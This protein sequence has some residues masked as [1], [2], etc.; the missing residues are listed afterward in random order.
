MPMADCAERISRAGFARASCHERSTTVSTNYCLRRSDFI[1]KSL[2]FLFVRHRTTAY[3][4]V[5]LRRV[6]EPL[7]TTGARLRGATSVIKYALAHHNARSGP[8]ATRPLRKIRVRATSAL[9]MARLAAWPRG[10]GT[11]G[12]DPSAARSRRGEGA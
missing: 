6:T 9:P 5:P 2:G 3:D 1:A 11:A 7:V 8:V 12:S 10:C 4:A